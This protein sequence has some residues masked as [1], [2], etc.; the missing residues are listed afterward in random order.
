MRFLLLSTGNLFTKKKR[1]IKHNSFK[2]ERSN[3]RQV[4]MFLFLYKF[5]L[6]TECVRG[7]RGRRRRG[8]REENLI[9]L[10]LP[11]VYSWWFVCSRYIIYPRLEYN[12]LIRDK[13]GNIWILFIYL[14]LKTVHLVYKH[15]SNI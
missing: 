7:G 2:V 11:T 5:L 14:L 10:H 1:I 6:E 3:K 8:G 9:C 15:K 12:T 4:G 13:R